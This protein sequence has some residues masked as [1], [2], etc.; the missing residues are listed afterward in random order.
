MGSRDRLSALRVVTP[1]EV[2][3]SSMSMTGDD[4]VRFCGQCRKNV[5]D[6]ARLGR[7]EALALVERAEGGVGVCVRLTTRADGTLVTGDC[8]A[9]LRRARKRGRLALL[10]ALPVVLALQMG[11]IATGVRAFFGQRTMGA[12]RPVTMGEP[13]G[14]PSLPLAKPRPM[15]E[16]M[17]KMAAPVS[18]PRR[19]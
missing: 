8:W 2:P 13:V 5:Y 14:R 1:C 9:R 16:L 7:A 6:V 17:G 11:A 3:W 18:P 10:A 4:S 15:P 19:K 12:M